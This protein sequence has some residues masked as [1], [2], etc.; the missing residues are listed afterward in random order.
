MTVYS[1]INVVTFLISEGCEFILT[2]RLCL[3]IVEENF[4]RQRGLGRRNGNP[5]IRDFWYNDNTLRIERSCVPVEGNT[6][7]ENVKK[8]PSWSTVDNTKLKKRKKS[9]EM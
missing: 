8:K 6:K 2:E 3:V 7:G 9:L 5:T 4:G 1:M